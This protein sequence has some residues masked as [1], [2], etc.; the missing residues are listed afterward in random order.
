MKLLSYGKINLGLRVLGKRPDGYH[1]IETILQTVDLH[2]DIDF[3]PADD[4]IQV[5]CSHRLVPEDETNLAWKS[6]Q[7]LKSSYGVQKG[8]RITLEKTIP[9]GSGMGGGSSNAAATLR[10]AA[11][12]WGLSLSEDEF[13]PLAVRIGS[14]VPFFLKGGTALATGRGQDLDFF[15]P[16]WGEETF[17]IIYPHIEVSSAWAYKSIK[18]DLTKTGKYVNLKSLFEKGT[19]SQSGPMAFMAN[20]LEEGV[21]SRYPVIGKAKETLLSQGAIAAAMTGSGSAVYGLF[22]TREEARKAAHRIDQPGWGVFLTKPINLCR[23]GVSRG[24]Y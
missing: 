12:V 15:E 13:F 10:G 3:Q 2:D 21:N 7:L 8:L 24:D 19:F 16:A 22:V 18:L 23:G 1:E 4:G 9:V 11:R 20:D 6:A 5:F 17:I 14:D